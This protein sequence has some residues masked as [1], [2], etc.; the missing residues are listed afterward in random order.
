MNSTPLLP[1]GRTLALVALCAPALLASCAESAPVAP[2]RPA[3]IQASVA[4]REARRDDEALAA[5]RRATA[6]FRDLGA[7]IAEGYV[8]L[9]G[10]EV[11]PDEGP[12]GTV[13][14]H[15]GRLL[16]GAIDAS[17][18]DGLIYEPRKKGGPR[19]VGVELAVP[20]ALWPGTEAPS[21]LGAGFQREDEF[22]VFGLH[23]WL[24]RK[25]PEG[26]FA[27]SNREVS[28]AAE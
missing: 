18:P 28:C 13:Y 23:V 21:F 12:V 8:F 1:I 11:R 26:L 3:A 2:E 4:A 15:M 19:L 25:N 6:R 5:L 7:A 14:I 10:C 16:D 22:G 20:Y 24:W 9:H 17:R 27:E